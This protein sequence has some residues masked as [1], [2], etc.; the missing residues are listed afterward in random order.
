MTIR[1]VEPSG[2]RGPRPTP[3]ERWYGDPRPRSRSEDTEQADC[4]PSAQ[5]AHRGN[6]AGVREGQSQSEPDRFEQHM[7][8]ELRAKAVGERLISGMAH[9][10]AA[11]PI[12]LKRQF[13]QD[14]FA[15]LK[16]TD[17]ITF[18][19]L[20]KMAPD[21]V[22]NTLSGPNVRVLDIDAIHARRVRLR[23]QMRIDP[24][25][26]SIR[27]FYSPGCYR[28]ALEQGRAGRSH[29]EQIQD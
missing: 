2:E 7:V 13:F 19:D 28:R 24:V 11:T 12:S 10:H 27:Q 9:V 29:S 22:K 26:R 5:L 6:R 15:D 14:R 1:E 18:A 4:E 21:I 17:A 16:T 8:K 25:S 20:A 3:E 23:D